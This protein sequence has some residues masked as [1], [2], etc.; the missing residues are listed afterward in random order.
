MIV[1]S[2]LSRIPKND[3]QMFSRHSR[4]AFFGSIPM[5]A[6]RCTDLHPVLGV[7][8]T[9]PTQ[10]HALLALWNTRTSS[11]VNPGRYLPVSPFRLSGLVCQSAWMYRILIYAINGRD[12][13]YYVGPPLFSFLFSYIVRSFRHIPIGRLDCLFASPT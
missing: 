13:I 6:I 4:A 3:Y 10:I 2:R 11:Q 5:P 12:K 8:S 1:S 9:F 7:L